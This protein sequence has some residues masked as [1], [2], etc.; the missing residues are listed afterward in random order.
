[1]R[2]QCVFR[3]WLAEA[4]HCT[5]SETLIKG[6]KCVFQFLRDKIGR[7]KQYECVHASYFGP[8]KRKHTVVILRE[9][10]RAKKRNGGASLYECL[11]VIVV[12][13]DALEDKFVTNSKPEIPVKT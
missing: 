8:H 11:R 13:M 4:D 3:L 5:D 6:T 7:F 1:M 2:L 9:T 10:T 12:D